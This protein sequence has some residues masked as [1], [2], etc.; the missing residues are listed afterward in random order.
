MFV[1]CSTA[2]SGSPKCLVC[3]QNTLHSH[4]P[5]G[6]VSRARI[7]VSQCGTYEFQVLFITKDK[8]TVTSEDELHQL[9]RMLSK[10]SGYKFC[11]GMNKDEYNE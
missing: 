4:P 1:V 7:I 2:L 5:A 11:P 10:S 9:C 3:S 8:G 6:L